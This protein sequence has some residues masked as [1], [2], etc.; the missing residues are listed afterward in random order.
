MAWSDR[1][2]EAALIARRMHKK[3][4]YIDDNPGGEW[5]KRQMLNAARAAHGREGSGQGRSSIQ[6]VMYGK[7]GVK[8]PMTGSV[9]TVLRARPA[10][11]AARCHKAAPRSEADCAVAE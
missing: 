8:R 7:Q 9:T 11:E 2:R 6:S 10:D 5:L 1:A 4:G 3:L